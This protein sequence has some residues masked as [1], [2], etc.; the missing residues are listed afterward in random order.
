MNDG[1]IK[2][3]FSYVNDTLLV[4]KQQDVKRIHKLFNGSDRN[5]KFIVY[6]KSAVVIIQLL[7]SFQPFS[8]YS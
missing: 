3:Y 8:D 1:T 5:L 4:V 6:L 2:F 7:F